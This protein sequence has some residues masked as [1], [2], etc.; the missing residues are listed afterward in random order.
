MGHRDMPWTLYVSHIL[1]SILLHD[2]LTCHQLSLPCLCIR[3][4]SLHFF[5][6]VVRSL[7]RYLREQSSPLQQLIA[8]CCAVRVFWPL[9]YFLK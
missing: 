4:E 5:A 7:I 6:D 9:Q 3:Q 8:H 1:P 2:F